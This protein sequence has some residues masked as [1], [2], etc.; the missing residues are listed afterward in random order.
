MIIG[1]LVKD[2]FDDKICKLAYSTHIKQTYGF[3][4][5]NLDDWLLLDRIDYDNADVLILLDDFSDAM[6]FKSLSTKCKILGITQRTSWIGEPLS[7]LCD[8]IVCHID[9]IDDLYR[10]INDGI[11]ELAH[12]VG[13]ANTKIRKG[14]TRTI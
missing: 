9:T 3:T 6:C 14:I 1:L 8:Y 11:A 7:E 10:D 2:T 4:I 5:L 12:L 13:Y